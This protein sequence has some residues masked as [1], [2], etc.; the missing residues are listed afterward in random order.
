[1]ELSN[2]DRQGQRWPNQP[3]SLAQHAFTRVPIQH[4]RDQPRIRP[5][6][7]TLP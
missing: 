3:S 4:N 6:L 1:M 2:L 5:K 7:P